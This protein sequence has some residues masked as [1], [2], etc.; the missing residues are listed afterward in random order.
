VNILFFSEP[1]WPLHPG[2]AGHCSFLYAAELVRRGH[3]VA[4]VC[5]GESLVSE[6][7]EGVEI[8]RVPPERVPA[9]RNRRTEENAL[10]RGFLNYTRDHVLPRG[11]DL[12][13]DCGGFLSYFF[14]SYV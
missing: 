14:F 5:P 1:A 7:L 8:H 11:I 6:V 4:L 2:G 13:I 10:A 12:I 9:A 3:N